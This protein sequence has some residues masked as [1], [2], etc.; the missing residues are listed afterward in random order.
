MPGIEYYFTTISP[1][2]YLAGTRLEDIAARHGAAI[3]YRPVDAAVLFARTGGTPLA[4]RHDNRKAYRLQELRR[5]A[6]KREMPINPRPAHFPT[7]P[8]PAAYAVIAAQEAG[9]G[10]IGA[11]V[12]GL[13][14]ACWAEERDIA[15]DA[16]IRAALEAAGF[17]PGLADRGLLAGAETY[18]RNL[19]QA[20]AQGAFGVPFYVVGD[21]RFWGQ[22][23]LE[24]L[25][26]HL[27]GRL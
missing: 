20:I 4:E 21:E 6:A 25:A 9:G 22:D 12:H 2:V 8:A 7:N 3:T 13:A 27:D 19:E 17:D 24:D 10:D 16:V 26:L 18:T 14:R 5:Q 23:R 11:L 15:D 1:F